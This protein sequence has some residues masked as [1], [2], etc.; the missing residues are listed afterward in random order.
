MGGFGG[1]L[2][3]RSLTSGRPPVTEPRHETF[4][5]RNSR[6]LPPTLA[7]LN[8]LWATVGSPQVRAGQLSSSPLESEGSIVLTGSWARLGVVSESLSFR[9]SP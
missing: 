7:S 5:R 3:Q 6:T 9:R 1:T 8:T 4:V 2:E